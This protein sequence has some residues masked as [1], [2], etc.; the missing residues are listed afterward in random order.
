MSSS[1]F[2]DEDLNMLEDGRVGICNSLLH[3]ALA[4]RFDVL[5]SNSF[6]S[7]LKIWELFFVNLLEV[8][9]FVLNSTIEL[10]ECG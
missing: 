6:L 5:S 7:I 8:F 9:I 4:V 3:S 2:V 1:N 10:L